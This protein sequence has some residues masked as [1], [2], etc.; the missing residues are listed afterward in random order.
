MKNIKIDLLIV[1]L[2]L[3]IMAYSINMFRLDLFQTINSQNVQPV[4]TIIIR[5]N[6]VQRCVADRVLWDR[7]V[8]KSPVYMGDLIRTAELSAA[9]IA[10]EGHQIDLGENTLIRIQPVTDGGALQIELVEGS[11]GAVTTE[12]CRGLQ[13]N[14]M[15]RT[16]EVSKGTTFSAVAGKDGL[17]VQVTEG[18]AVFIEEGASRE[19]A[20]GTIIALDAEGVERRVPQA[21]V[22]QPRPNARYVKSVPQPFP[23]GFV[24]NRIN[25]QP[26]DPL[27]LEIAADRGFSHIV[28]TAENLN[29]SVEIPLEA[30]LWNWRLSHKDTILSTG[31]LAVVEASNLNPL[32]PARGSLFRYQDDQPSLRFQWSEIEE[33]SYYVIEIA[34][35][36]DFTNLQINRQI[37]AP[38][39]V[40]SGLG[41]GTWYWHVQPVFSAAYEGSSVF[42]PV[43]FFL[44]EQTAVEGTQTIALPEPE[45]K[46]PSP[47]PP[48]PLLPAPGSRQPSNGHR[49]GIEQLKTQRN[50]A[51]RWSTVPGANAY[52]LTLYEQTENGR[53]QINRVTVGNPAW[54]LED[55]SVLNRGTFIWQVEAVNRNPDG[56]IEQRGSAGENTFIMDIPLPSPVQMENPGV[57]YGL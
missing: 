27:R 29:A 36:P 47:L 15:G 24:W 26:E 38:F 19:I 10:M 56:T 48:S 9:T 28:Q 53:R 4:G 46:L 44:I 55:I 21:V 22:T 41:Q 16:V 49:I 7:L 57:L 37:T 2:C 1:I 13:L 20:S 40:D 11:L 14:L 52:V 33:A 3:S 18:K 39:F 35:T 31:R 5:D 51:F 25:L 50:I 34:S 54:T 12:E 43:S 17:A 23:V 32:S 8:V 45:P 30:G 6:I 42:S